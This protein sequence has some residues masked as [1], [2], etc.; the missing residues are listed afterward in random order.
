MK[1]KIFFC[2]GLLII[3]ALGIIHSW[4]GWHTFEWDGDTAIMALLDLGGW[5]PVIISWILKFTYFFTGY[6]IYTFLLLQI[7][8]F[9]LAL[10][11][12]VWAIYSKWHSIWSLALLLP[13]FTIQFYIMP[14][15]L[16]STS[17]SAIWIFLLYS[18]VLYGVLNPEFKHRWTKWSYCTIVGILFIIALLSRYNAIVQVWPITIIGIGLYLN[19]KELKTWSYLWRLGV[20]SFFSGLICI[21][22][23]IG[24][25]KALI[26]TELG[27]VYP[28]NAMFLGQITGSCIPKMD[29]TCFDDEWWTEDWIVKKDKMQELKRVYERIPTNSDVLY[30]SWHPNPAFVFYKELKGLHQKWFYAITKY[31]NNYFKHLSRYY[32]VMWHKKWNKRYFLNERVYDPA[33]FE[34]ISYGAHPHSRREISERRKIA[35]KFN[36]DELRFYWGEKEKSVVEYVIKYTFLPETIWMVYFNFILF[37]VAFVLWLF[38]RKNTFI[39]YFLCVSIAGSLSNLIIPVFT[40]LTL[41]RY[42]YP[43]YLFA[44][45]G[46]C[47][48]VVLLCLQ[49]P[50]LKNFIANRKKMLLNS[51]TKN[52]KAKK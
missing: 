20:C 18:L 2:I 40:S 50:Y 29:K 39:L 46:F 35:K 38:K 47:L 37:L 26:R 10:F 17:F 23:V 28:A 30:A 13:F 3:L 6:H 52:K 25:N 12:F 15:Q 9:Y 42:L 32:D 34:N 43:I 36:F 24:L 45:I 11:I 33:Q 7:I 41:S 8:P 51:K 22:L 14:L 48:F 44:T 4:L 49:L 1:N 19:K 31:P 16:M 27:G 21:G 5:H